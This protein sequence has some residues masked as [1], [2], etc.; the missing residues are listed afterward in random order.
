MGWFMLFTMQNVQ[1]MCLSHLL[2]GFL[3]V[4]RLQRMKACQVG[5][6]EQQAHIAH[7]YI[8]LE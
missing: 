6:V 1:R 8:F 4:H 3:V 7:L 2:P 5:Q